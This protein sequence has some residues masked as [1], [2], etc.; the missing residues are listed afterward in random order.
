VYRIN[1]KLRKKL[2]KPFG[3]LIKGSLSENKEKIDE[4][5][6]NQQSPIIISVGDM[7]SRDISEYNYNPIIIIIDNKCMRKKIASRKFSVEKV[8]H[9]RNPPG[10]ITEEAIK[11]IQDALEIGKRTQIVID[12]EEDLL[13]LIAILH[14]PEK[15]LIIYRQPKEGFVT[16]KVTEK[17]RIEARSIL[18]DMKILRKTK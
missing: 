11:A 4:I 16:I 13:T 10:T 2:H 1:S 18:K 12:G 3:I 15:A 14:A 7:V 5:I 8:F 9:A 6:R 17:K